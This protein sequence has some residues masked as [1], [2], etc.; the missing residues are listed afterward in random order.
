M[1]DP[2]ADPGGAP[3]AAPGADCP[4][5][6]PGLR[7]SDSL[8]GLYLAKLSS[9]TE[10]RHAR[11]NLQSP[12]RKKWFTELTGAAGEKAMDPHSNTATG[13]R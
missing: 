13:G 11:S 4:G 12:R 10:D 3:A 1:K 2:G 6:P 9:R 8:E 5:P 7:G